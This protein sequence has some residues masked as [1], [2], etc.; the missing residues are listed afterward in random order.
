MLPSN[1]QSL[2]LR[3][4]VRDE[5]KLLSDTAAAKLSTFQDATKARKP[6]ISLLLSAKALSDHISAIDPRY[7]PGL[8]LAAAINTEMH[9]LDTIVQTANAQIKANQF[10]DAYS[11]IGKYRSFADEEPRLKQIV[12]TT[13]K[14]HLDKGNQEIASASWKSAVIDLKAA[15][16]ITPLDAAKAS[17]ARAEAGLTAAN[18]KEAADRAMKI[19]AQRLEDGNTIGAYDILSELT[20]DQ[21]HLVSDRMTELRDPFVEAATK[22]AKELQDAHSP[23]HGRADEDAMRQ[24]YEYLARASKLSDNPEIGLKQDLMADTIARYYVD[25]ALKYLGKPLSSGVGVGWAFLNEAM[26]YRPNFD[27]IR[28]A[29]TSTKAA[30]QMRSRLSIGVLFRDQ[31]SRRDSAGFADQLQQA[32]ATGLETSGL[33]VQIILPGSAGTLQPNFQFV[34]EILQ[35]RPIRNEKK[36]TLQSRYRSGS[37][38]IPNEEWNKADQEY[39]GYLLTLQKAQGALSAAQVKSNKKAIDTANDEVNAVQEKV[40]KARARLNSIPKTVSNDVVSPYNYTRT[41]LDLTNIVELSFRTIDAN[42]SIVG[43][44]IHVIKGEKPKHFVILENIKPDDTEGIKEIDASPDETQLMTDVEIEARDAIV[45][46]AGERV[47][48]LPQKI[49]SLA[50]SRAAANDVDGAGESYVLYLNCTTAAP[51][52]ERTEATNYLNVNFNIRNTHNL[53]AS[54]Q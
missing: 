38:E 27:A 49:L 44:P 39:E 24:A 54:A 9:S 2:A 5:L 30:Y 29:L 48:D 15:V 40:Q 37:R 36:E 33:P 47:R 45:K 14:Y 3:D 1:P 16:E 7:V 25:V 21:Q 11:T 42:S 4:A 32:F 50:R 34:G 52:S 53:H 22:K 26:Q 18:N 23:I 28:D 13:Y 51:T 8:S 17:L 19:S 35:H 41:T 43:D 31:T 20:P 12:D 10:D 46:A 6:G